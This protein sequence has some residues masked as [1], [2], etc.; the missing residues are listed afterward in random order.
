M[1]VCQVCREDA[2]GEEGDGSRRR[3]ENASVG[4]RDEKVF[5]GSGD[6]RSRGKAWSFSGGGGGEGE[7]EKGKRSREGEEEGDSCNHRCSCH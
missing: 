6:E 7:G 4:S 3:G 5:A 1:D 2:D